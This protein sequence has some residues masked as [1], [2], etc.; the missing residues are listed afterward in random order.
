MEEVDRYEF[1]SKI[2]G[3]GSLKIWKELYND[4][5]KFRKA[6]AEKG[7]DLEFQIIKNLSA[8]SINELN[9]LSGKHN[10]NVLICGIR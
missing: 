4:N 10:L 5:K 6:V 7:S 3:E 1:A 9:Y 8:M 2:I